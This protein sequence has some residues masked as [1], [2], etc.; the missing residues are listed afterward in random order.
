MGSLCEPG[1]CDAGMAV[2]KLNIEAG[3]NKM[4][5]GVVTILLFFDELQR[6]GY[7]GQNNSIAEATKAGQA[8]LREQLLPKWA[9]VDTWGRGYWDWVCAVQCIEHTYY[10][11]NY[12]MD[13]KQEFPNWRNDARNVMSMFL[14]HTSVSMESMTDVYGGAWAYPE[15]CDAAACRCGMRRWRW[16]RRLPGTESRPTASGGREMARRQN[17]LATYDVHDTGVTEDDIKGG[18]IVNR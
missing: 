2:S 1:G 14:N 10:L 3:D 8:Y 12:L 13:H 7:H 11:A 5:G 6:L 18:V 4:T 9:A 15:N 16:R 17:L